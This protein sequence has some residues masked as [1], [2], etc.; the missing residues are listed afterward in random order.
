L[1]TRFAPDLL[2]VDGLFQWTGR[3]QAGAT[4]Q[5][6]V[7]GR[8]GVPHG[9][10][11]AEFN[12]T[13]TG[14]LSAGF[15]TVYPCD[16]PRPV[17]SNVNYVTGQTVA[18]AVYAKLDPAGL[19]CIYAKAAT[20]VVVDVNAYAPATSFLTALT[21]ARVLDTR[22]GLPTVDGLFAGT[23]MV[24]TRSPFV[25]QVG[26]R[27]GVPADAAAVVLNVTVAEP[28]ASGFA[29]VYPC[30]Q[31]VPL[32]SNVNFVAG[33]TVADTVVTK[34]APDGTVCVYSSAATQSAIDV[35]AYIP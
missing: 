10:V 18:N 33:A 23:G 34:L 28:T 35:D 4:L 1:E 11:A 14:A 29:T 24:A 2:T 15:L 30:D 9:A 31:P 21:P 6:W 13:A 8:G 3:I 5:L 27:G 32:A 7:A 17:A 12:V 22:D 19:V 20:D 25:L 16:Q 26:G